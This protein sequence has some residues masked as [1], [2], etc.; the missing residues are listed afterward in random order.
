MSSSALMSIGTRA[1]TASYA[2]L[3]TTGNN[4]ANAN[5]V[6]YSRQQVELATAGGQYTGMGFFGRGVDVTTVSRAH[7]AFLVREA[8][9]TQA[10]ASADQERLAQLEQLERVFGT[11]ERPVSRMMTDSGTGGGPLTLNT[12]RSRASSES[13]IA[14]AASSSW[15]KWN[16]GSKPSTVGT[17]G[18]LRNAASVP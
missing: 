6:G 8:Q 15:M 5:T 18:P 12:P 16:S 3:Q 9:L 2:A 13:T 17:R 11:G 4:I 10:I 7:D 1:M 14:A